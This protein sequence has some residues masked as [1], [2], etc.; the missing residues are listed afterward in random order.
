MASNVETLIRGAVTK[1]IGK[2]ADFNRKR[3]PRP[4]D[5]HPFL[6]GIHKP[7]EEEVTLENL[8][9]DGEIPTS[10]TGRYLR[11]GPNPAAEPDPA[12]YHWFS[13]AGMVHGIRIADGKADWYRN[14]WVRGTEACA[15]LGE[16]IPPGTRAE[17]GFDAPNTNVVGIAGRTF[18]IVE[19]GGKPV[20]LGYELNTLAHNPFDGTLAGS[21]TA[22]PHEDPATGEL[23]AITYKGDEPNKVWHVV[24]DKDAHVVRE[25]AIA[26]SDG[27]SIHDCAIT[28]NYVLVFDLPVT[29]S[30]KMLLGGYRFPYAWNDAH[31]ARVGLLPRKGRGDDVVW[32]PVEP[33]YVFHPANAHET[34]DG[35]VVVDV[36]AHETMFASSKRGPD[37]EKS[38][39]ERWTI[40]PAAGTIVRTVIHDH[41]QE[42]PRYDERLTTRPYRYIYSVA[43]PDGVSSEWALADTRL[44]RHDLEQG[45]T[46]IHDFGSGRHPGEFVFVPRSEAGA[47]DDGWLIGLVVD[48]ND[49]TTDLVILNADDFTGSPQAV[50]HLPHRVPPG[51]HGNWVAD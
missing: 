19:A 12:S 21:Y 49:E 29:F 32:V 39:M 34:A 9:I 4:T 10:L 42:F 44:F 43:I 2:V 25:E 47:E 20:E 31:Q 36:V 23:H 15:V 33:C 24:L 35:K 51:F 13:G 50:V 30:M 38:R 27:P 45:T 17:G 6:T 18:A 16:P 11:N 46:A 3:L 22:H 40:D 8:R 41:A 5:A 7:M 37:S 1:G 26:V 14:R 28:E 48:M